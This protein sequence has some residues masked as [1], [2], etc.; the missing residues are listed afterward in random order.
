M[1]TRVYIDNFRSF[2]NFEY[3]PEKKQLLLG[4]NGSGKSSLLEV[5]R[6]L[7]SF[8]K[9]DSNQF[10]QSTRTRWIDSPA[11]VFELEAGLTARGSSIVWNLA[12]NW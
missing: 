6:R 2:Q 12:M 1:L 8:V 11:Q 7:K 5:L 10:T 4:A 3:K 9:G